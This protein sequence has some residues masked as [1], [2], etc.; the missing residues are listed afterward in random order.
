MQTSRKKGKKGKNKFSNSAIWMWQ[1]L[2]MCA[3]KN[4]K[5]LLARVTRNKQTETG[6]GTGKG[7]VDFTRKVAKNTIP[8]KEN[9]SRKQNEIQLEN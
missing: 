2:Q 7:S 4:S 9:K 6:R 3:L 8:L 1:L 5:D